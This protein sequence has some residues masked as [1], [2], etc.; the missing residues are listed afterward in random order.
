MIGPICI[1][2]KNKY[3]G[4]VSSLNLRYEVHFE[5]LSIMKAPLFEEKDSYRTAPTPNMAR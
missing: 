1:S 4:G 3:I 5:K 2:P